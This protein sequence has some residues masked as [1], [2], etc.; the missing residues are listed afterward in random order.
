MA[1][2]RFARDT[3]IDSFTTAATDVVNSRAEL[4]ADIQRNIVYLRDLTEPNLLIIPP[5]P[6]GGGARLVVSPTSLY[7][8]RTPDYGI[9]GRRTVDVG[10]T[11]ELLSVIDLRAAI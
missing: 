10:G 7:I 3:I 5:P 8:V 6:G 11:V 2:F 1:R 4:L 9:I